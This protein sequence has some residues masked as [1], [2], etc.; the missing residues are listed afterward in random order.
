MR[1]F[2]TFV[3]VGALALFPVLAFGQGE[4]TITGKVMDSDGNPLPGAN[5]I[6]KS[7]DVG[8]ATDISG[9]FTFRV[10]AKYVQGQSVELTAR[11]IGFHTKTTS[12]TLRTGTVAQ[13]FV[14]EVDVLDMDAVV[15]TG[16]VD[17]TPK[18][19]LAFSVG[20]IDQEL[21]EHAPASSPEHALRGKIAG[22]KVIQGS[23][24]PGVDAS[25]LLRAPTSINA[26]G[27]SQDPLYIVDG[28]IIDPSI[29]GSP[30]SDINADDI[31]N[32]EVVKGAAGASLYGSRAANGVVNIT[33]NRGKGLALNQ[34]RIRIRNEFGINFLQK[35]YPLNRSHWFRIHEETNEYTDANGVKVTPGDFIDNEGNFV[36]PREGGAREGSRY[37]GNYDPDNP[38]PDRMS[39][40]FFSDNPYKWVST[41]DIVIDEN[42][43]SVLD[44]ATGQPVG[45]RRI[46]G[47][48]VDNFN[49]FF[50]PGTFVSNSVSI[51]RNM[52]S[53]NFNVSL[54]NLGQQGV[55][56]GLNGYKRQTVR[57]GVDHRF[58]E[59]LSISVS[60][61]F[62]N[63][64]RDDI[65]TYSGSAFFGIAFISADA[66]LEER[67]LPV[68]TLTSVYPDGIPQDVGGELFVLPDPY[69]ARDNPLYEPATAD[70]KHSQTR[71]MGGG[72][73]TYEPFDWLEVD[74]NFSYDRSNRERNRFFRI[75]YQ[76]AFDLDIA[77][78]R[79]QKFPAFDEALNGSV[80]AFA[81]HSLF[82][83]DL[84][85]RAK[86]RG[87]FEK[88]EFQD[89]WAEGN[90]FV[91]RGVRD[92]EAT[93]PLKSEI[94]SEIREVRSEGYSMI[95]SLDY[96]D[97]YIG[98][99]LVRRDGS[100]LFGPDERWHTYYRGSGAYRL[101]EEGW[102][103]FPGIQEFKLRGSYGT[104]GGRPNFFAR[105]ET[106]SISGGAVVKNTL[107][108]RDLK[109]ESA[110]ELELG[111]DLAFLDRF[112]LELTRAESTVE[113]QLLE[114][115][116][117]SYVGYTTQWQNAGTLETSTWEVGLQGVLIQKRDMSLT[118]GVNFDRT[119][120]TISELKVAPY[121]YNPPFQSVSVFRIEEGEDFGAL[122]GETLTRN[123]R[124]LLERGLS[125]AELS[126]FDVND[127][128]YVVWVGDGNTFKDGISKQLWGTSTTLSG[129]NP[130]AGIY[131]WGMPIVFEDAEGTGQFLMGSTVPDFNWSFFTNLNWKGWSV[132]GLL[133]SQVGGDVWSLTEQWG[134]GI[135][136]R[137]AHVD[138]TG[139]AE[140][141]KKPTRY[142][143]WVQDAEDAF[144]F[145]GSFV[146]LRELSVKYSFNRNQLSG[147]FGGLLHKLS[148]GVIGRNLFS[149]DNYDR[150]TDPEV[151]ISLNNDQG[152]SSVISR[153]DAF[154][155]P[156]FRTFTGVLE[157]EL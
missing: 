79:V 116:L 57:I 137:S 87:L 108:N 83:D 14:L 43:S 16:L 61:F 60:G 130:H 136:Q 138:Q 18:T 148:I 93:D 131:E 97:R 94:D 122:Y 15:V 64:D 80:T 17:E 90:D 150:G 22:V 128:G 48:Y 151:G 119:R 155:Y 72:T 84:Q 111:V 46:D 42:L 120:Q 112:S 39:E 99:F 152:G 20:R 8:A 5:I 59:N 113:D 13:D 32:I 70:R 76:D 102:W 1:K 51:S 139:K 37:T 24:E 142:Y 106:W 118:F 71:V 52:K 58:R 54:G 4:A 40:I 121:I 146:K 85:I 89:T 67:H 56:Q 100:S 114:V 23:G 78:G 10:P 3:V 107:G 41:G 124:D 117:A 115:P 110:T 81:H 149:I 86:A 140:G 29:S 50:D 105:F 27:R 12:I 74:G 123:V 132:Y 98:D 96:K 33:T 134:Y 2:L 62:A 92:L 34:T 38:D 144:V 153:Y 125:E 31:I 82:N 109:P 75:G 47:N 65:T 11:F 28:V 55:I 6:I 129:D 156:N 157:I 73:L 9:D 143:D 25:V 66:D 145:D 104:A 77:L 68:G 126:Q 7:L 127:E 53:T 101:S 19:K 91:V 147:L 88:T 135:E 141:L 95:T 103:P 49:Q 154:N 36:D 26:E 133:E 21:L 35:E 44:P 69:A 30:L 63:V 45:L